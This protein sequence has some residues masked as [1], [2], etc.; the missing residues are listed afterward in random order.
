MEVGGGGSIPQGGREVIAE[1]G[2][3]GEP[4]REG[5]AVIG[6]HLKPSVAV[7]AIG[8]IGAVHFEKDC[9]VEDRLPRQPFGRPDLKRPTIC[10]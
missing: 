1:A 9:A 7:G 10:Y 3:R 5:R 4:E 6:A 8:E 2:R